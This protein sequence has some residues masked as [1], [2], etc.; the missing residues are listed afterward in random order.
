MNTARYVVGV[1]LLMSLPPGIL[2]WYAIH[3]FVRVWRRIGAGWTYAILSPFVVAWM[4]F[5]FIVR[6][7]LLVR[8]LGTHFL[9]LIPILLCAVLGSVIAWK[10]R[11]HLTYRIVTG[12]PELSPQKHT[13]KLLTE[14]L[15]ATIRHPRYVEV[16]L[17]TAAYAFFANHVGSYIAGALSVPALYVVVLMEEKE[18]RDRFGTE[19]EDYCRR[20]P[21]FFPRGIRD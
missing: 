20:V 13:S 11:R 18:L 14:G 1:L 12:L 6:D 16:I 7:A 19:Y 4:V 2:L 8:D 21:R 15:Y 3:P 5:A 17:F 10:R 9:L